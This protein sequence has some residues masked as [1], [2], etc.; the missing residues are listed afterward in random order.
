LALSPLKIIP[1]VLTKSAQSPTG[2]M[3]PGVSGPTPNVTQDYA[4]WQ[5]MTGNSVKDVRKSM[6][7]DW[8]KKWA[9]ERYKDLGYKLGAR[10]Y[11]FDSSKFSN[12]YYDKNNQLLN[13]GRL[14]A[15]GRT[16]DQGNM[17]NF[18]D[19]LMAQYQGQ[20]PS[21]AQNQY[22]QNVDQNIK[23]ALAIGNRSP[24]AMRSAQYSVGDMNAQA[25]NQSAQI[26]AQEQMMAGQMLQQQQ[27]QIQSGV[28]EQQKANDQLVQYYTSQGLSLDQAQWAAQM[29]L[30]NMKGQQH[31]GAQSIANKIGA[32]GGGGGNF[33]GNLTGGVLQAGSTLGAASIMAS[34]K[35]LKREIRNVPKED[36]DEFLTKI[37]G[38]R[39]RYNDSKYGEGEQFSPMAQDLE[40]TKIGKAMVIDTPEGKM[41]DYGK[42]F[43]AL[44]AAQAEL[45]GKVKKLEGGK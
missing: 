40:K 8:Q 2:G 4:N 26:R 9:E 44:L 13:S 22:R 24:A 25:A 1:S 30:E 14:D 18:E 29:E 19:M 35:K 38:Y 37:K 43:G 10:P 12:Q 16:L 42:G 45:Y 34:D 15:S 28:L 7:L 32:P 27:A 36:L 41:V 11:E 3:T 23:A 20:G 21:L 6:G 17:R 5:K 31:L 39:Y 33:W